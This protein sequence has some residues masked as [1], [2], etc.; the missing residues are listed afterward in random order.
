MHPTSRLPI[1]FSRAINTT[2]VKKAGQLQ[3]NLKMKNVNLPSRDIYIFE[4][5][6]LKL[7]NTTTQN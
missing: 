4:T 7:F 6:E 5:K 1:P 3:E 2:T